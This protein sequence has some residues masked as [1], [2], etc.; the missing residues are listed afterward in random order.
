[1]RLALE[2]LECQEMAEDIGR[3]LGRHEEFL[4]L[5]HYERLEGVRNYFTGKRFEGGLVSD[6]GTPL[7]IL[8]KVKEI[9]AV[10]SDKGDWRDEWSD[11]YSTGKLMLLLMATLVADLTPTRKII[12]DTH[13]L[14]MIFN[15]TVDDKPS[16]ATLGACP[17][18][19][20]KTIAMGTITEE[21]LVGRDVPAPSPD[22]GRDGTVSVPDSDSESG[23]GATAEGSGGGGGVEAGEA[24]ATGGGGGA[25]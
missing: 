20:F 7:E 18:V 24:T 25:A 5:P 10:T 4:K 6:P 2:T 8:E 21:H 11:Q 9:H 23:E 1:M 19:P 16:T 12:R 13:A 15:A 3:N 22:A 17:P 14:R